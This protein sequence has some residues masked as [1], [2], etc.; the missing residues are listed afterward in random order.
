MIQKTKKV[1]VQDLCQYIK[2]DSEFFG[3]NIARIS[4]TTLNEYELLDVIKWCKTNKID[5]LYFLVDPACQ[6]TNYLAMDN[7]FYFVDIR[8][9]LS[10]DLDKK[11]AIIH[12]PD[13]CVV[14]SYEESDLSLLSEIAS[15]SHKDTRFY[16]DPKFPD[17]LCTSLYKRW[18]EKSC[19]GFADIVLVAELEGKVV[20]YIS[21][22]LDDLSTGRIGLIAVKSDVRGLG[23]GTEL[24]ISALQWFS[25]N[26]VDKVSVVTQGRNIASQKL[27]QKCGFKSYSTMIWYHKW[28]NKR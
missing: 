26:R 14:R 22:H 19:K 8:V 11:M 10:I 23:V 6:S 5:C 25:K 7:Q 9:T 17:A 1:K 16:F 12:N 24:V 2:W 3:L 4:R 18:I 21:C 20:G 15:V 27:Y 13:S 28:F